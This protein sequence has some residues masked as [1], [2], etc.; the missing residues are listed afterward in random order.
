MVDSNYR[1]SGYEPDELT[2]AP[3]RYILPTTVTTTGFVQLIPQGS[4][5][6]DLPV[7]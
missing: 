7:R 4:Q 3:I 2:T 1:P 5:V 6:V